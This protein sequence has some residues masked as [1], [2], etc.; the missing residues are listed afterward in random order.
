MFSAATK[1]VNAPTTQTLT[2]LQSANQTNA[3]TSSFTFTSQNI[4]TA[5]SDRYIVIA[6]TGGNGSTTNITGVTIGGNAM[7]KENGNASAAGTVSA[8]YRLLVTTGTSATVVVTFSSATTLF[9][10][11]NM[12]ALTG[13]G[14]I[15]A[16][17][18]TFTTTTA[19]SNVVSGTL[20]NTAG[21]AAIMIAG[22][23]QSTAPTVTAF[24]GCTVADTNVAINTSNRTWCGH[25]APTTLATS[26]TFSVTFSGGSTNS[27]T[28]VAY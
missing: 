16:P 12:Y 10:C 22:R 5:S 8:I 21:G 4:G 2:F 17:Y 15:S 13:F 18:S 11:I 23:F 20:N 19:V 14:T 6:I 27:A 7:T 1:A 9:C 24:A 25:L 28:A 3:G 26:K